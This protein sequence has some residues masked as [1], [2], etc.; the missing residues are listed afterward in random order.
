MNNSKDFYGFSHLVKND[1]IW[2]NHNLPRA[3][4]AKTGFIEIRM[5]REMLQRALNPLVQVKCC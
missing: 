5:L 4:K 2:M 1:V 3:R